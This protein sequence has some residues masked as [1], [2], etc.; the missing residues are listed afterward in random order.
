VKSDHKEELKELQGAAKDIAAM[1]AGTERAP[2]RDVPPAEA[3]PA[4]VWRERY[5]DHPLVGTIARRLIWNFTADGSTRAG[6]WSG[7]R[8]VDVSDR[9]LD[10]PDDSEVELWHPIGRSV[11]DVLAW[12][13]WIE[14]TRSDSRSSRRTA[15]SICS[16]TPSGEPATYSN[17]F[18]AARAAAAP[19]QRA[20]R[21]ARL[22]EQAPH[23]RG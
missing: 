18:A 1:L 21:G 22:E 6:I 12:R 5:L 17:R 23:A 7:D 15:R 3:W 4:A 8:V 10:V 14:R 11:E 13:G 19:V 16:P 2:R 20:L 9:P